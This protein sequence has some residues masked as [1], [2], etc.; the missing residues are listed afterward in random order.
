[1][2][3]FADCF[4]P[5][6][7]EELKALKRKEDYRE[8]AI[9]LGY[10]GPKPLHVPDFNYADCMEEFMEAYPK[11]I[12][13][14]WNPYWRWEPKKLSA[15]DILSVMDLRFK[16]IAWELHDMYKID[17]DYC[18]LCW[19][20]DNTLALCLAYREDEY[21]IPLV[22]CSYT[23]EDYHHLD[24]VSNKISDFYDYGGVIED[25]KNL[26]GF[27]SYNVHCLEDFLYMSGVQPKISDSGL[28]ISN[29]PAKYP[30]LNGARVLAADEDGM[31]NVQFIVKRS[32]EYNPERYI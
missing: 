29:N 18:T 30:N 12:I 27:P 15:R 20:N 32:S 22:T 4:L 24:F 14:A 13:E 17:H 2:A 10:I 3:D 31:Q 1:M 6:T 23:N 25:G 26:V 16:I 28:F 19:S 9:S 5:P 21:Y 7:E 11:P 8:L